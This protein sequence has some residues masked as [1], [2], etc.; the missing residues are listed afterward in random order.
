MIVLLLQIVVKRS[1][2]LTFEIVGE[3]VEEHPQGVLSI[4][5]SSGV[6]SVHKPVDYEEIHRLKVTHA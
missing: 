6:I 4:D 3:G 5:K 2:P 1:Y